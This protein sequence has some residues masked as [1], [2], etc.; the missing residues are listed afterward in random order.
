MTPEL[1]RYY[2]SRAD[3]MQ[4]DAWRD[5]IADLQGMRNATDKLSIVKSSDDLWFRKGELSIIDWMLNL[6]DMSEKAYQQLKE[7]DAET[8]A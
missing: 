3:M 7:D 4:S 1:Q 6:Q 5:L 8:D 2:E